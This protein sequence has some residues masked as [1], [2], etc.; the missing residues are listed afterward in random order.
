[1]SSIVKSANQRLFPFP[2]NVDCQA[3][4]FQPLSLG[5]LLKQFRGPQS[6]VIL[7]A[8]KRHSYHP[9]EVRVLGAVCQELGTEAKYDFFYY[10]IIPM[11][12]CN[13]NKSSFPQCNER[14]SLLTLDVIPRPLWPFCLHQLLFSSLQPLPPSSPGI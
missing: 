8:C 3:A 2:W 5:P 11:H 12:V 6:L 9:G 10:S 1:M 7:L 4:I 14:V 13:F